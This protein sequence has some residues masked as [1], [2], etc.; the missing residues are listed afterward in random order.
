MATTATNVHVELQSGTDRTL[1]VTWAC[2]NE[3]VDHYIV[4]WQYTAGDKKNGDYIWFEGS[5][6]NV[7]N[8][9]LKT[10]T[11][12]APA[13][14]KK[15]RVSIRPIA[16]KRKQNK[17]EQAYWTVPAST[18]VPKTFTSVADA[19]TP[20]SGP[21]LV[22][23]GTK[24]VASLLI[25]DENSKEIQFQIYN[26]T[27]SKTV[28]TSKGI[29][30]TVNAATYSHKVS[31][32][33]KYKARCRC[34]N[35]ADKWSDWGP[36]SEVCVTKP[37]KV[38]SLKSIKA[39]STTS[40]LL[41]WTYVKTADDYTIEYATSISYFDKSSSLV[42]TATA[43][44]SI[45]QLDGLETGQTYYF[46]IRANNTAGSSAWFPDY[47]AKIIANTISITLGAVPY[48]PTTWSD[49]TVVKKGDPIVLNWVHNPSDGSDQKTARINYSING[50]PASTI[51]VV[52]EIY[53]WTIETSD[54]DDSSNITWVIATAGA[55]SSYGPDST[56]RSV[57]VYENPTVSCSIQNGDTITGY[58]FVFTLTAK[59]DTQN[60]LAYNV[61]IKSMQGYE[62]QDEFGN[63]TYI[64]EQQIIY[65]KIISDSS[66]NY[67][68]SLTPGD[69][70]MDNNKTYMLDF[71]VTMSSGLSDSAYVIFN[72]AWVE[73][74]MYP[75]AFIGIMESTLSAL[76]QAYCE[77]VN[78][79]P[80]TDVILSVYRRDYNGEF[81]AIQ[82]DIDSVGLNIVDPHPALD[83]ARYRVVSM[84][85][86][87]GAIDFTDIPGVEVGI[88]E[89]IIQW[90]DSW[91]HYSGDSE[92]ELVD[93][94][95]S[96]SILRLPYNIDV[97]DNYKPD[98][99][100]IE[101]IGRKRPVSYY[102]TQLGETATW[103]VEVP[104]TDKETIYSLRRLAIW[105]GD[106]YV[107]EPSGSGYWAHIEVS[108]TQTHLELS[109]PVS[110]TITR[111]EG[112]V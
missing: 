64:A 71:S 81:T 14:A 41:D 10:N 79:N 55:T 85:K 17:T 61:S 101:Y 103:S 3:H 2:S 87:T 29:T 19:A 108:M 48:A 74:T 33:D 5:S 16:K 15:A 84:S 4:K 100:L 69:I 39:L 80:V 109:I 26:I 25:T 72:T 1:L 91:S 6:T 65:Q 45:L 60:V 110:L 73:A 7:D 18:F 59:P 67:E 62:T 97:S 12:D 34:A 49:S 66:H 20:T 44:T 98:V 56:T 37:T 46:R 86:T 99:E 95:M 53:Q 54:F 57:M 23:S 90:E 51:T 104:A 78:G 11:Y 35:S 40:V 22:L 82:T 21:S 107:R 31:S 68:V 42:S 111:V 58:P 32:G 50:I 77:D 38:T 75:N 36:W 89:I 24:I 93:P 47:S 94:I 112:G 63:P 28:D 96:G 27:D 92:D 76:I 30:I 106:V 8:G 43:S 13:N 52:G 102:G 88:K 9:D 105:Q 83:F 70:N